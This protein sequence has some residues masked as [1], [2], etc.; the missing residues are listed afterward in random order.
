MAQP[1]GHPD[2]REPLDYV[3]PEERTSWELLPEAERRPDQSALILAYVFFIAGVLVGV[4]AC[5]AYLRF[6]G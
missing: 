1:H 6:G 4:G 3:T 2:R 5:W